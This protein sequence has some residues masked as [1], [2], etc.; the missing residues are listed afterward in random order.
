MKSKNRWLALDYHC[1]AWINRKIINLAWGGAVDRPVGIVAHGGYPYYLLIIFL[2][3]A[4]N[5]NPGIYQEY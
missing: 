1:E 2:Q 5:L 4:T 3:H